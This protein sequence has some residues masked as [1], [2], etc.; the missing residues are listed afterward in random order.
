[1]PSTDPCERVCDRAI[2]APNCSTDRTACLTDCNATLA[3]F[4]GCRTQLEALFTCGANTG[5]ACMPGGM[6][7][8]TFPSCSAQTSAAQACVLPML[9]ASVPPDGST[10]DPTRP[11]AGGTYSGTARECSWLPGRAFSC[12]PGR[13]LTVG[14]NSTT[15]TGTLCTSTIGSCTGD[16]IIRVCSGSAPCSNAAE[17]TSADD[18]CGTCPVATVVCPPSGSIYVMTGNFSTTRTGTCSPIVR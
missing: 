8:L 11:C 9:D 15:G 6:G 1:V 14:C 4:S 13:N 17:L 16:P 10:T 3:R 2:V 18:T 12:T 5:V 7:G